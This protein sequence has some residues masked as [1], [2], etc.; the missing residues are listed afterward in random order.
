MAVVSTTFLGLVGAVSPLATYLTEEIL[1]DDSSGSQAL[2][3]F[4]DVFHHRLTSFV[5]RAH[6]RATPLAEVR[7]DASDRTSCRSLSAVGRSANAG[8]A[9]SARASLALAP[10]LG[11]RPGS[12]AALEASL[13][14]AFPMWTFH[15]ED[16]LLGLPTHGREGA[17]RMGAST[18]VT[19]RAKHPPF[20][21]SPAEGVRIVVAGVA[22]TSG[23]DVLTEPQTRARLRALVASILG[24]S[25]R[26]EIEVWL[27]PERQP[28]ARLGAG[29]ARLGR[30]ALVLRANTPRQVRARF[31]LTGAGEDAAPVFLV[32][33]R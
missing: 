21:G 14:L 9:L 28:R 22:P 13:R 2:R 20:T 10:L 6:L 25:A 23:G 12:R 27:P 19:R 30:H 33:R 18:I 8:A 26:V 7:L 11:R 29:G 17:P 4:Y 1:G 5:Y 24:S 15:V 31:S 3:D 16:F 32:S